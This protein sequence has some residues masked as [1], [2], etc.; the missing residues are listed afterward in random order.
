MR[1]AAGE[2]AAARRALEAA[3]FQVDADAR[4]R[5]SCG[6]TGAPDGATVSRLLAAAGIYP[7]EL[8]RRRDSLEDVFLRLTGPAARRPPP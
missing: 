7:D 3:G 2:I 8:I 6:S 5:G 1:L 4:R